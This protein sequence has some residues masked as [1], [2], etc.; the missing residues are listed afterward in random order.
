L[1]IGAIPAPGNLLGNLLTAVASLFD[2]VA[3]G[4]ILQEAP[5]TL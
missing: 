2:G 4:A 1:D 5:D 3:L